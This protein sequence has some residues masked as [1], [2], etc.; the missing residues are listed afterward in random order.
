MLSRLAAYQSITCGLMTNSL[1]CGVI[2][3]IEGWRGFNLLVLQ[4]PASSGP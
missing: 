4:S 3:P 2:I 1:N